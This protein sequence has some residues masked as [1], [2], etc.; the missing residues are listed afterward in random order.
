MSL[1]PSDPESAL[2]YT[3][4]VGL[5]EVDLHL[6]QCRSLKAKRGI[7]ARTL[8]HLRKHHSLS[9]AEVGDQDVW[10]RAGLAAVVVSGDRAIAERSLRG[11]VGTL[12]RDRDVQLVDYSI[13]F[14]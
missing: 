1:P 4:V 14:L 12:E 6:P 7:L 13:Q 3:V 5:L 10:G 9:V 2:G 8:N 11:A